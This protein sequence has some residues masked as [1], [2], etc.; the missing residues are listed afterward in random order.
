MSA[1]PRSAS[2]DRTWAS[3]VGDIPDVALRVVEVTISTRN[4]SPV[5]TP[6][7]RRLQSWGHHRPVEVHRV[8]LGGRPVLGGD[9]HRHRGLPPGEIHLVAC[10]AGAGVG[11]GRAVL[12]AGVAVRQR[13]GHRHPGRVAIHDHGIRRGAGGEA[14]HAGPVDRQRAQVGVVAAGSGRRLRAPR[15]VAGVVRR[16]HPHRVLDAV[17]QAGDL[18]WAGGGGRLPGGLRPEPRSGRRS[19]TPRRSR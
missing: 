6:S 17:G 10:R 4:V 1:W 11:I 13:G 8:D 2:A 19:S 18:I 14:V 16:T 3:V 9:R 12:H 5:G 15:A 7:G